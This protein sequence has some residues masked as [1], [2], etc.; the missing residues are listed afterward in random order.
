VNLVLTSI[1]LAAQST[2]KT[3]PI[4]L[5]VL[6]G[7]GSLLLFASAGL[8][9]HRR[10][11]VRKD[12]LV[13]L[14]D[15]AE[16]ENESDREIQEVIASL[17]RADVLIKEMSDEIQRKAELARQ[18]RDENDRAR[19]LLELDREQLQA[20]RDYVGG[21]VKAQLGKTSRLEIFISVALFFAGVLVS[22]V[23][24]LVIR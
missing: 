18:L 23:V 16:R 13:R 11:K 10:W 22:V 7:L 24:A 8:A 4:P 1:G 20:V 6:A 17:G 9:A 19:R 3:P 14:E 21:E 12:V 15:V 5:L 2:D